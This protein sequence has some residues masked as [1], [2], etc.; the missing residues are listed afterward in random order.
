LKEIAMRTVSVAQAK[1]QLPALLQAAEAGEKVLI[2]RHG[3]PIAEVR[4]ITESSQKSW[5]DGLEWLAERRKHYPLAKTDSATLIRE[6]R[7]ESDS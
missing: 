5:T 4:A 7:D 3:K 6:M 2:T 1:A